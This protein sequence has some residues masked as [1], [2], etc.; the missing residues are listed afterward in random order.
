LGDGGEGGLGEKV[1]GGGVGEEEAADFEVEVAV[2]PAGFFEELLALVGGLVE[3]ELEEAFNL[4]VALGC[5]ALRRMVAGKQKAG[6]G[7][8]SGPGGHQVFAGG[9][10]AVS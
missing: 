9:L 1:V 6:R 3:D 10:A 2:S 5:H 4:G 8:K 7:G